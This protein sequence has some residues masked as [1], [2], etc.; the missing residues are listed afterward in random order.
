MDFP[1]K[2]D[3]LR[4]GLLSPGPYH[5]HLSTSYELLNLPMKSLGYAAVGLIV[6]VQFVRP[7]AVRNVR[8]EINVVKV[9]ML[10]FELLEHLIEAVDQG[11]HQVSTLFGFDYV[12]SHEYRPEPGSG[13]SNPHDPN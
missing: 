12:L 11:S 1:G 4:W 8:T 7:I 5:I 9:V 2:T 6:E 3:T 13:E 10:I